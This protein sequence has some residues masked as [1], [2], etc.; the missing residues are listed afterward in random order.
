M[1]LYVGLRFRYLPRSGTKSEFWTLVRV[2]R[3][4]TSGSTR[5]NKS[6]RFES[7]SSCLASGGG[8]FEAMFDL[9]LLNGLQLLI[10]E[11]RAPGLAAL[12]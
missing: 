5:S 3:V 10:P 6:T 8:L 2:D 7:Y 1:R 12:D 4:A 11:V 9:A